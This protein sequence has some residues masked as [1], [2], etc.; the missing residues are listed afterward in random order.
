MAGTGKLRPGL[1]ATGMA[2]A[3]AAVLALL[4]TLLATPPADAASRYKVVTKTFS[5]SQPITILAGGSATPYPSEKNASGFKKG[6][7]LDAN[8]TLKNFSHTFPDDVDVMI[9]H[10][11]V[12]RTVMS[13]VGDSPDAINITL[14]LDDEAASPLP[15]FSQLTGGTFRPTNA[16]DG[17]MDFFNAPAPDPSGL[18]KL[19][20]FDGK[21]PNGPWQLWVMDDVG[22]DGGQVAGGWSIT[23]R[24]R[25]LR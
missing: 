19:S 9:S 18:A 8:L 11:G 24:A 16:Y 5:N 25:V 12:N 23:I 1:I 10:R 13:D 14:K 17:F 2:L 4:A 22:I 20:G 21:N 3:L 6:K 15:D 7:I